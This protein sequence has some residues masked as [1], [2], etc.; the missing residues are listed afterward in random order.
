METSDIIKLCH[1]LFV[2]N[3]RKGLEQVVHRIDG[4]FKIP[5]LKKYM[6]LPLHHPDLETVYCCPALV[7]CEGLAFY[8]KWPKME[9]SLHFLLRWHGMIADE[10]NEWILNYPHMFNAYIQPGV[11]FE[12]LDDLNFCTPNPEKPSRAKVDF[13]FP[14]NYYVE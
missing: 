11:T 3:W 7:I 2:P 14:T 4:K 5:L 10:S 8:H 6:K 13:E 9:V 12:N 1:D